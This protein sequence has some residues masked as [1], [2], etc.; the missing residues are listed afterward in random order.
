MQGCCFSASCGA[1]GQRG[2]KQEPADKTKKKQAMK[3]IQMKA[4]KKIEHTI[5]KHKK[6]KKQMKHKKQTQPYRQSNER[7]CQIKKY[8]N[9]S[10]AQTKSNQIQHSAQSKTANT[11]PQKKFPK[12]HADAN[13]NI[14]QQTSLC[15]RL[16][17]IC[18]RRPAP[19]RVER[20]AA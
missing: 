4:N 1:A 18:E 6:H 14:S 8:Q 5:S 3:Q 20:S 7:Q 9:R 17:G 10:Q 13:D 11:A 16:A 2:S 19:A 15:R 12:Q